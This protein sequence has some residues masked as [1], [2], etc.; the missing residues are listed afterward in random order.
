[1]VGQS[2]KVDVID[3]LVNTLRNLG[4]PFPDPPDWVSFKIPKYVGKNWRAFYLKNG[5]LPLP[6]VKAP[7]ITTDHTLAETNET[8]FIFEI[9][10]GFEITPPADGNGLPL[11]NLGFA[12]AIAWQDGQLGLK[13]SSSGDS[14]FKPFSEIGR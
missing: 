12:I 13:I 3:T 8:D 9:P 11:Q 5:S 2:G 1:L 7:F 6:T 14:K 10:T 4:I